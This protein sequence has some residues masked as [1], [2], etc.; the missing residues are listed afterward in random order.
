MRALI[1]INQGFR[2]AARQRADFNRLYESDEE[3]HRK[4]VEAGA[5][6]RLRA[7]HEAVKP[8]AER[9]IRMYVSL[10]AREAS[11]SAGEHQAIISDSG[12]RRGRAGR[13]DQLAA[14]GGA[15]L[16]RQ[17]R[18][19]E[20]GGGEGDVG[21]RLLQVDAFTDRAFAGNP[22]AVC[23]LERP[24]DAAWMQDVAREMNPSETAFASRRRLRPPVVHV[25]GAE[26]DSCGHATLATA[27]VLWTEGLLAPG[28]HRA[29]PNPLRAWLTADRRGDWIELDFPSQAVTPHEPPP[30][31]LGAPSASVRSTSG[32]T[33]PIS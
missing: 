9:Y 25:L 16:P 29:I 22:A 33:R 3:F 26:V 19:R 32:R 8:Q 12:T 1:R 24:A 11:V 23:L 21:L 28:R 6:P 2:R 13:A 14:R 7:L 4:Y 17:W 15:A 27:H 20:R 18:R 31:L 10:L 30:G 5:G